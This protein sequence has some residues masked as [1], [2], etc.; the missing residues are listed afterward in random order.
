MPD[1]LLDWSAR[2]DKLLA[3]A[4]EAGIVKPHVRISRRLP[5]PHIEIPEVEAWCKELHSK[6]L[7]DQTLCLVE[8]CGGFGK[9]T[10]ALAVALKLQERGDSFSQVMLPLSVSLPR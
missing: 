10:F 7:E 2:L 8:G 9:S 5:K 6:Q 3:D 4:K 1:R